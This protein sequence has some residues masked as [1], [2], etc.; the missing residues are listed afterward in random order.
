MQVF[1]SISS[2]QKIIFFLLF[3]TL[4]FCDSKEE[5]QKVHSSQMLYLKG[6]ITEE[7]VDNFIVQFYNLPSK[8]NVIVYID[9]NGGSVM[10]GNK[11]ITLFENHPVN[12]IAEKAYSMGFAIFQSCQ[13]RYVLEH[14][15]L[16]QHQ[17]FALM[18]NE[19]EKMKS[20]IFFLN[21]LSENL[22]EKQSKRIGIEPQIFKEKINN[23]WW[24]TAK[25]AV[26]EN[27]ADKIVS[28]SI[29]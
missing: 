12:C 24:L 10:A 26:R 27:V 4:P 20:Y 8:E 21:D 17:M 16:M 13:E 9:T 14:S 7:L 1:F 19:L 2:L 28:F 22:I 6:D 11:I 5:F 23:D 25:N 15:T 3:L 18:A 29:I